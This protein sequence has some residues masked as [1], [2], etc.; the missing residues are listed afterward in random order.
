M[1]I[2]ALPTVAH[3]VEVAE[4]VGATLHIEP[5]DIPLA[6]AP[7]DIWF[8]LTQTGG[9]IVPLE[10]C[11]CFL[12]VY[13]ASNTEIATPSLTPVSAE[14]YADIPGA[15]VTFPAVGAYELVLTG[16]PANDK[17]FAP[18]T[19]RF[20]VTVAR[21]ADTAPSLEETTAN[22][23][24]TPAQESAG[25]GLPAEAEVAME[26]ETPL[27]ASSS[28]PGRSLVPWGGVMLVAGALWGVIGSLRS[29]GGKA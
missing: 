25:N 5:N 19:L 23:A 20:E 10:D 11:D 21:Q 17:Q 29:P 22:Q 16:T 24:T 15:S 27:P 6:G 1:W 28:F 9:I 3:Q 8:A 4:D 26:T 18:F 7:S 14:G 13:D 2:V 12:A